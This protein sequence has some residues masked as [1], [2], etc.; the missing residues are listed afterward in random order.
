[1][2]QTAMAERLLAVHGLHPTQQMNC[3]YSLG[4]LSRTEGILLEIANDQPSFAVD[5]PI[6]SLGQ[7]LK[8]PP[9]R[10]FPKAT[11]SRR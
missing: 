4:V 9:F 7:E 3:E 6:G 11:V 5:E 10:L 2:S 1:V 8:L